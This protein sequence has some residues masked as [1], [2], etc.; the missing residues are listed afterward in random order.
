MRN[1]TGL[2]LRFSRGYIETSDWKL[3][4][5][6]K[7][8]D[9]EIIRL[10]RNS[11]R[12]F[13]IYNNLCL[14]FFMFLEEIR[15]WSHRKVRRR[16]SREQKKTA[17]ITWLRQIM[18]KLNSWKLRKWVGMFSIY[19]IFFT[20]PF[21]LKV[22]LGYPFTHLWAGRR[23]IISLSESWGKK[24]ALKIYTVREL[25]LCHTLLGQRHATEG[26]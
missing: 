25:L 3:R 9:D 12:H 26:A 13:C 10:H 15:A 21:G 2:I 18:R 8:Q 1:N 23:S 19:P 16:A 14:F 11:E 17:Q 5:P 20:F 6:V 7:C 4:H 22:R 24:N